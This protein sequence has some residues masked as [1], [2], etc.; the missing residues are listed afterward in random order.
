VVALNLPDNFRAYRRELPC[1]TACNFLRMRRTAPP[2]LRRIRLFVAGF[3]PLN[4]PMN[5]AVNF[6]LH[7][8][9]TA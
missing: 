1:Q 2:E 5:Y 7:R 4:L 9:F 6:R 3:C 8:K